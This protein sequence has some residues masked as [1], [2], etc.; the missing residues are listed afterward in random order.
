MKQ[1]QK[2]RYCKQCGKVIDY[3]GRKIQK[4]TK[5][6]SYDCHEDYLF[7]RRIRNAELRKNAKETNKEKRRNYDSST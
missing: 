6:C 7:D 3:S 2:I 5:Y 4:R 1:S